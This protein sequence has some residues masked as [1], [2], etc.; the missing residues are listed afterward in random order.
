MMKITEKLR[1]KFINRMMKPW[2]VERE[3]ILTI[4]PLRLWEVGLATDELLE[5]I[6][7]NRKKKRPYNKQVI[8]DSISLINR[9]GSSDYGVFIVSRGG[10]SNSNNKEGYEYRYFNVKD[11]DTIDGEKRKILYKGEILDIKETNLEYHE[12]KT[13]PQEAQLKE[14]QAQN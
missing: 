8:Y 2:S 5:K 11:P 1:D 9:F 6:N 4:R 12:K 14:I 13:I 7:E 10:Y 3:I